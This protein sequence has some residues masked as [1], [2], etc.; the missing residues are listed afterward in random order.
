MAKLSL[1]MM[2]A[3]T[4]G[5]V[6]QSPV[7]GVEFVAP[8]EPVAQGDVTQIVIKGMTAG[9]KVEGSWRGEPLQ[10]FET[11]QGDYGSLVGIDLRLKPGAYPLEVHVNPPADRSWTWRKNLEV[12]DTDYGVQRLTLPEGMVTLDAATLK[13][14]RKEGARFS[15]LWPKR[16]AN[17]YW[18]GNFVRPVPGKLT[19]PFGLGRILN[20]EP[21]SPHSGVDMRAA[22]G[23]PVRAAN[24]GRVILVGEFYFH[25]KAVVI[26]HGW[27]LYTMYF[28][29]SQVKVAERDLVG[30]N[31]IIG[32][33]GSTGRS[34]APHLHWGVRLGGARV[35]PLAL[36]RATEG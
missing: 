27:G 19:T 17:R 31:A 16:T 13:R 20:G 29:L 4:Y 23:D 30:K 34:T 15:A 5:L 24:H 12:V 7:D 2:I 6:M 22:L 8:P 28:H 21:R 10:F 9:S 25:G 3:L 14:V 1:M 18:R 33:A 32:L 36:I 35:D 11:A 26:D